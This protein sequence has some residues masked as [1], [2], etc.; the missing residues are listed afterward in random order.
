VLTSHVSLTT[1][2]IEA[3][4]EFWPLQ[5][6]FR[7]SRG[8]RTEAHVIVVSVTEGEYTGGGEGVPIARYNQTAATVL[9]QIESI[10]TVRDLNRDKRR[11]K[12]WEL[13]ELLPAAAALRFMAILGD[14]WDSV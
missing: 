2:K 5:H 13:F 3:K 11:A 10:R 4:E 1:L 8:S 9:E 6:P 12:G 7:I 14:G